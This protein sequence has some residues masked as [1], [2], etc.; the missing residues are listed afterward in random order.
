MKKFL[1]VSNSS[2]PAAVDEEDFESCKLYK[3]NCIK[4]KTGYYIRSHL[5]DS[6]IVNLSNFIM[7]DFE[8]MYD[9]KDRNSF[10]NQK[11]NLRK[12]DYSKNSY[13]RN[14]CGRRMS[15]IY[16]GAYWCKKEGVWRAQIYLNG[17]QIYL[18]S[19]SKEKEAARSYNRA[20][21]QYFGEFAATNT[22]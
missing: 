4:T 16:K 1:F 15:S 17:K 3:W 22:V 11:E 8:N 21:K 9:H 12:C 10:N 6:N 5:S 19:F 20:A 14:K 7:N 2:R 18:G 13:N